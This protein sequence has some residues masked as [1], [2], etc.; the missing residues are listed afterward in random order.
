[1][2]FPP[3]EEG[4]FLQVSLDEVTWPCWHSGSM[5]SYEWEEKEGGQWWLVQGA[6]TGE[7]TSFPS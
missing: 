2:G 3:E 7:G 6:S 5:A 4:F 1:M